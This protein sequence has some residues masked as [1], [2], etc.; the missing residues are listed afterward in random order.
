MQPAGSKRKVG[1]DCD[2]AS[3]KA[4]AARLGRAQEKALE[5]AHTVRLIDEISIRLSAPTGRPTAE[6]RLQ[7][8]LERVRAWSAPHPSGRMTSFFG[9]L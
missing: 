6:E 5:E 7:K 4:K 8:I 9:V 2:G 3:R 1:Q